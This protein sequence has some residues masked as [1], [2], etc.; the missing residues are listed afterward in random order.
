MKDLVAYV[1][2]TSLIL[3]YS[4]TYTILL[5]HRPLT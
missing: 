5:S 2:F 3:S 4:A 1:K